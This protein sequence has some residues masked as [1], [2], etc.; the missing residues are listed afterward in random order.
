M[1]EL[2]ASTIVDSIAVLGRMLDTFEELPA[3]PV[4]IYVDLE[5]IDLSRNGTISI[6][7]LYILPQDHTFLVDVHTL[8]S[9]AF[10]TFAT[11]GTTSLK[12][13]LES[14][15]IPKAFFDVRNDSD[16]LYSHFSIHLAG[17][18][19]IQL[20]ELAARSLSRRTVNGLAK[21]I[22]RDAPISST[23]RLAWKATKEKGLNLFAPERGG[24]YEVFNERPPAPDIVLYCVQDVRILSKLFLL[25]QSKLDS[26]WKEKVKEATRDRIIL[27]QGVDYNGQGRH[28]ALAPAGWY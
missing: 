18:E 13:I 16:A 5:G 28:M 19:D 14:D 21:C 24:R 26:A 22:E 3:S 8:Q 10:S 25:Y 12:T 27:S 15:T 1:A 9:Q 23:E 4:S 17:I 6:L 2:P 20:M 7:Q 11:N